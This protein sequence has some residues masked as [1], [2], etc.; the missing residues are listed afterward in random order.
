MTA[1]GAPAG[2]PAVHEDGWT[3]SA[4]GLRLYWQAW[5]PAG[6][7][8]A[9]LVLVH[10]L[11][12]HSGRY[13][14]TAAHFARRGFAVW[15]GDYRGHGKSPG[16]RVHVSS[17]EAYVADVEAV[18]QLAI[19][20]LDG[21]P[22]FLAGH[23]QGGL[24]VL[25]LALAR[26][27][28]WPGVVVTSPFLAVHPQSRPGP[29]KRLAAAVLR[30]VAPG[31]RLATGIDVRLLSRDPTVGERYAAD[32]LVSGRASAGWLAAVTRAQAEVL[33]AARRWRVPALVMAGG[34]DRLTDP[35]RTRWFAE[36][37]PAGVVDFAWWDGFYHE[38]LN[39]I[40]REEVYA[41]IEGWIE[42]RIAEARP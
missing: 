10:G 24:V 9:G 22:V 18:R 16:P 26:G 34:G 32:P 38:L 1:P 36:Q 28:A 23:S 8:R 29:T 39:E 17:V 5:R 33:A 31:L 2:G 25:K 15:A 21:R 41:R 4:D 30:R 13:A 14:A 37:A 12:E 20:A 11:A 7:A 6:P 3:P 42:R 27:E 35:A 19:A 40:G